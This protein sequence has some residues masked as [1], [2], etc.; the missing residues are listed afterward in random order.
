MLKEDYHLEVELEL[1]LA[2]SALLEAHLSVLKFLHQLLLLT[3]K[4]Q[5]E[6][7]QMA[8]ALL[9]LL[10]QLFHKNTDLTLMRDFLKLLGHNLGEHVPIALKVINLLLLLLFDL[11]FHG[12]D[13]D[14]MVGVFYDNVHFHLLLFFLRYLNLALLLSILDESLNFT[15]FQV[16]LVANCLNTSFLLL[17]ALVIFHFLVV[18][19]VLIIADVHEILLILES[20]L[21]LKKLLAELNNVRLCLLDI[22]Q[23]NGEPDNHKLLLLN[24]CLVEDTSFVG[25]HE[26]LLEFSLDLN[27]LSLDTLQTHSPSLALLLLLICD[28]LLKFFQ[29]LLLVFIHVIKRLVHPFLAHKLFVKLVFLFFKN[30][31]VSTEHAFQTTLA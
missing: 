19:S 3:L 24:A 7:T 6:V 4:I 18:L 31:L 28:T 30:E 25:L 12:L 26:I 29:T 11:F 21:L 2:I 27:D 5:N 9:I 14:L 13:V 22:V 8:Q 15:D 10:L 17:E 16:F 23:G 1:F 20:L